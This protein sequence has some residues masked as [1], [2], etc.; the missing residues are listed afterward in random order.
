MYRI[1]PNSKTTP[2]VLIFAGMVICGTIRPL[3]LLWVGAAVF[4]SWDDDNT[5]R[6][7]W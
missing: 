6:I 5:S 7:V 4:G 3:Q 1:F 2:K